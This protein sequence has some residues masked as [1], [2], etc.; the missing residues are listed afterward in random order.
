MGKCFSL[1]PVQYKNSSR[2]PQLCFVQGLVVKLGLGDPS[3]P[4]RSEEARVHSRAS[5]KKKCLF[6][7]K[8]ESQIHSLIYS[9]NPPTDIYIL[10]L[11][12][13]D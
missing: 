8:A 3:I 10:S 1:D 13:N 2:H 9:I 7:S 4:T 11:P 5:K 6:V 12:N